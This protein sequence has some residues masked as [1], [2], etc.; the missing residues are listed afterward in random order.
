[1]PVTD[2]V[3]LCRSAESSSKT[4]IE[5]LEY[6]LVAEPGKLIPLLRLL[7]ANKGESRYALALALAERHPETW[8]L[9]YSWIPQSSFAY[10]KASRLWL[11]RA[12]GA[13][14]IAASFNACRFFAGEERRFGLCL[15]IET[16]LRQGPRSARDAKR[17]FEECDVVFAVEENTKWYRASCAAWLV[18]RATETSATAALSEAEVWRRVNRL[19]PSPRHWLNH[20]DLMREG[21]IRGR[22]AVASLARER[23]A[24]LGDAWND[25]R[26]SGSGARAFAR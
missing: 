15:A 25:P 3:L 10:A 19:Q 1:M 17:F 16:L 20:D 13:D 14:S 2:L 18:A 21:E 4:E 8:V 24:A 23:L 22:E 12:K 11:E 7:G 9:G 6:E 5:Q 26:L